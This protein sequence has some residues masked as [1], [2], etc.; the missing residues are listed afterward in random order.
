VDITGSTGITF[1]H[2]SSPEQR[3]IVESMSGGVTIIDYDRDGWPDI[4][5]TN[6][7]SV[8][9]AMSGKKS[10][11]ALYH[12]NHDGTFTDL[13][14]KAGVAYLCWVADQACSLLLAIVGRES[15][16][17]APSRKH[18][19]ADC[20]FAAPCRISSLTRQNH[21]GRRGSMSEMSA[22]SLPNRPNQGF[23]A[24]E[25][26]V[27]DTQVLGIETKSRNCHE[28]RQQRYIGP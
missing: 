16:D 20:G 27:P 15:S 22:K 1:E 8:E 2:L 21:S 24:P 5:F 7:Q 23:L 11:S 17:A 14:D 12:N 13:T 9:M 6:A 10:R 19:A 28:R 4:F 26:A 18:A 25:K 3:Y